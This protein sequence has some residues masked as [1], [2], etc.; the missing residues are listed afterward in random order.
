MKNPSGMYQN[1][2]HEIRELKLLYYA[3]LYRNHGDIVLWYFQ[4]IHEAVFQNYVFRMFNM[5]ITLVN[6]LD[7]T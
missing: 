3:V 5:L 2:D 4:I 1:V 7:H 6:F